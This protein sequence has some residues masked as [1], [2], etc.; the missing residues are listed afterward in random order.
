MRGEI[1]HHAHEEASCLQVV[2]LLGFK[3]VLPASNSRVETAATM[4]GR[5]GQERVRVE[6]RSSMADLITIQAEGLRA[7]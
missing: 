1:E 2:E 5:F 6:L 7:V 3:N 4:P